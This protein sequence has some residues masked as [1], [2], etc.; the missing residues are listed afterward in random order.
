MTWL[1]PWIAGIAAAIA[2][3]ALL[4]LY[5]L[6]LRRRDVEISTTLLWKK[7]IEDLQ[8]NAPFQKLRKNIL[9]LLQLIALGA[10]LTALGQ[11]QIQS[12][13]P[14]GRKHIILID[15]SASMSALDETDERGGARTR[16][17]AAKEE[18]L[19]FISTLR[20]PGLFD[21][22]SGDEAMVIAYDVAG[23]VRQT[24]TSDK[25]LL[26]EAIR[27]IEP[28][29]SPTAAEEAFRLAKAHAPVRFVEEQGLV[30]G[31]PVTMHLWSDGRLP[32]AAKIAP[33][34]EDSVVYH[35][36][37]TPDAA[38]IGITSLRADR[39]FDDPNKLSIF[40]GLHNTDSTQRVVDVEL[41]VDGVVAAIRPVTVAPATVANAPSGEDAGQGEANEAA[42]ASVR[43]PGTGGTVFSMERP[44]GG[45]VTVRIAPT[46][47]GPNVLATDDAAF[48]VVPPAKRLAVA[49]VTRGNLFISTA[50]EGL[51]LSK[52]E[53]FTPEQYEAVRAAGRAGDFDVTV[54]DG[55]LPTVAEAEGEAG[56]S[57]PPGRFLIFNALPAPPLGVV[58]TGEPTAAVMIDWSRDH[59]ALRG[60]S[61]DGIDAITRMPPV[62]IPQGS[63]AATIATA[64]TG[65][66]ILDIGSA[67]TR[68]IVVAF[69][70][71]HSDW[72]FDVSFVVF[73]AQAVG[74]LG[75]DGAGLGQM[76]KP[77][78]TLADRLP[79]GAT[80]V[81]LN[82]PQGPAADLRPA[83]DGRIVFGPIK[84]SGVYT[85][86]WKGPAGPRDA[87]IGGRSVRP[88]AANLLDP[89]ES[90][91]GT[92]ERLELAS[93]VVGAQA[94]GPTQGTRRLWP[95]LALAALG[96]IMFEWFVYNRKVQL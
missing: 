30:G 36:V 16:L 54:L 39:A 96:V 64:S 22:G 6:K 13:M 95:W 8:A 87:E 74:Y 79:I 37:G 66:A 9:L 40:V 55:Y 65:P 33:G 34:N 12:E 2:V 53:T 70:P 19:N 44:Q 82:P 10:A 20:E 94:S 1:T 51:P 60:I 29:D 72:P 81:R 47:R 76:V 67:A 46:T 25:D 43:T 17:D 92:V 35:A 73:L 69:D 91:I 21:R 86:S 18:A 61:L 84:T 32:D 28:T 68:A 56:A 57:L 23:E 52:L 31:P 11:P 63:A 88:F 59:P 42:A 85:V 50:L 75:D 7:A 49:V 83:P 15:R 26:A 58:A 93:R 41:M 24:F 48:L 71:A 77:G 90:D 5:F 78:G 27:G 4:I 38:N 62:E 3:P 89:A 14:T 80:D 45:I